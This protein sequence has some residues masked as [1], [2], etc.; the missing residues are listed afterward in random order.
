MARYLA[1]DIGAS[2]GR[3]ILGTI[4]NGKLVLEEIYRFANG[5]KNAEGKLLWDIDALRR[6]VLAGIR[7]AG[8]LGKAPDTV[9]IDTWGCDYVLLDASGSPILPVYAY[10]DSRTVAVQD[11]AERRMPFK[12]MYRRTGIQHQNF[13]T[14]YQ[15][16]CDSISG[17]LDQAERFLMIPEYLSYVLTGEKANEY[18]NATTTGMVNASS[19]DWDKDILKAFD[20]PERIFETPKMPGTLVGHFTPEVQKYMGFDAQV[21]LSPS[22]DTASAVAACPLD[23]N[24]VYISSGTWSLVGSENSEAVISEKSLEYNFTNEGGVEHRFRYLKNIMGTWLFQN[25]RRELNTTFPDMIAQA[26]AAEDFTIFDVN[27]DLLLAPESM[28]QAIRTLMEK[29]DA[30]IG[31]VLNSAYHSLGKA[32]GDV[33]RQIEETTGKPIDRVMIVGGGSQDQYL[34]EMTVRYTWKPVWTGLK[35]ATATG[36]L[37]AQIMYTEKLNLTEA[38]KIVENTFP[39]YVTTI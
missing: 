36:N 38:R 39:M 18:T 14:V 15:L 37:L 16:F 8:E 19:Y 33:V 6:E 29:P 32:Y 25:I 28:V 21:V 35:E 27:D 34:N 13:N 17:K 22:H 1:V 9:A 20:I 23:E 12:E 26:Q 10:R 24:T 3:H 31:E 11:E 7:H 30:P 5:Y 4:E 2:S